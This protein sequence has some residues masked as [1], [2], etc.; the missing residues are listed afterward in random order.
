MG[1]VHAFGPGGADGSPHKPADAHAGLHRVAAPADR[2]TRGPR[3]PVRTSGSAI[4]AA[5]LLGHA[6]AARPPGHSRGHADDPGRHGRLPLAPAPVRP[7]RSPVQ[8]RHGALA[9]P[10]ASPFFAAAAGDTVPDALRAPID[11]PGCADSASR[12]LAAP[13]GAPVRCTLVRSSADPGRSA[14]TPPLRPGIADMRTPAPALAPPASPP[15]PEA[16]RART[17]GLGNDC[18]LARAIAGRSVPYSSRTR[19]LPAGLT[20]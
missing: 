12:C 2:R 4:A 5:R 8:H 11:P 16:L 9:N 17:C 1:R 19:G 20:R 18:L 10:D 6:A 14:G 15:R 13:P 3:K 7:A